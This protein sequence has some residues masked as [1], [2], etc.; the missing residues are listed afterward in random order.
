[1]SILDTIS[2]LDTNQLERIVAEHQAAQRTT[3]GRDYV[4]ARVKLTRVDGFA[5]ASA[6][7]AAAI[8]GLFERTGFTG[9]REKAGAPLRW[10]ALAERFRDELSD[11]EFEALT[12]SFD[13][14]AVPA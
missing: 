5:A 12:A 13:A 6:E 2:T 7:V 9:G 11:H 3:L 10:A 14:V 1:M 8:S 4:A